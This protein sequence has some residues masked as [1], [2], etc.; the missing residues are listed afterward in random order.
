L[1]EVSILVLLTCLVASGELL[2]WERT[3]QQT[4][5]RFSNCEKCSQ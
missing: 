1:F 3:P 4:L 2:L 5:R